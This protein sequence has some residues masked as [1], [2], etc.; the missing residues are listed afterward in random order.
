MHIQTRIIGAI[1]NGSFSCLV[2]V[3]YFWVMLFFAHL[4]TERVDLSS[5][6]GAY[7]FREVGRAW[8]VLFFWQT[9]L[10]VVLAR[11]IS[12]GVCCMY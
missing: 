10:W 8:K 4:N 6:F 7:N 3:M 12:T 5:L 1:H 11:T 9:Q 2:W